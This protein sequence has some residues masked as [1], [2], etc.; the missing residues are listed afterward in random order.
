M[1]LSEYPTAELLLAGYLNA[2]ISNMQ[3]Y[4]SFDD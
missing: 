3:D 1:I 2:G 4:S